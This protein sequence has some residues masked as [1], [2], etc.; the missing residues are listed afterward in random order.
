MFLALIFHNFF[1]MLLC[2]HHL[3]VQVILQDLCQHTCM[4]MQIL[5]ISKFALRSESARRNKDCFDEEH[6]ESVRN[7]KISKYN[8]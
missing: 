2:H 5:L 1:E 7:V 4:I 6:F 8:A 3:K